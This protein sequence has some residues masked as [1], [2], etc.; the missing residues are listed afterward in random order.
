MADDFINKKL[1]QDPVVAGK[2][3]PEYPWIRGHSD[4]NGRV[5]NTHSDP[6]KPNESY[7]MNMSYDASFD[8]SLTMLD[9]PHKGVSYSAKNNTIAYNFQGSST[10][11]EG[12][13]DNYNRTSRQN[14]EGD[15]QTNV[16]GDIGE[17]GGGTNVRSY[18]SG[19]A[20][21]VVGESLADS[22]VYTSG[23]KTIRH[24]GSEYVHRDKDQM[25]TIGG[26]K[27]EV[28][29]DGEWG[30]HV[31]SGNWDTQVDA[32]KGRVF[33]QDE[34]LIESPTKIT[35]KVGGSTIVM[36]PSKITLISDRI[37]LNP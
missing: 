26:T 4:E 14:T 11:S 7:E 9:T 22:Y 8:V 31:Q 10:T 30:L 28:V 21:G 18:K 5:F 2:A 19:D 6:D 24:E 3:N 29:K 17:A 35:F 16:A 20:S 25:T 27:Y 34:L 36:E 32:G 33:V 1:P 15:S 12:G 37:D 23:D 13:S